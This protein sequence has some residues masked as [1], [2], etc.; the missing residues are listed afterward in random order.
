MCVCVYSLK[1]FTFLF[2]YFFSCFS[3]L[4]ISPPIFLHQPSKN[5]LWTSDIWLLFSDFR[6]SCVIV[7][8]FPFS[9]V[10]F[11][12]YK[13][14]L[15]I[16]QITYFQNHSTIPSHQCQYFHFLFSTFSDKDIWGRVT[17]VLYITI[18]ILE[19]FLVRVFYPEIYSEVCSQMSAV[20]SRKSDGRTLR[21]GNGW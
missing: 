9:Y 5:Q 20:G 6:L 21:F 19:L 2:F 10:L 8:F 15:S 14:L 11:T 7:L 18:S 13:L 3:H 4:L 1:A 12:F 16:L 17:F